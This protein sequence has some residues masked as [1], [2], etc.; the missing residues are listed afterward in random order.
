M[1]R[2]TINAMCA[3]F[4]GATDTDPWGDG[5]DAWKIGGKMFA[6]MGASD[7]GVSVKTDRIETAAMLIDAGIGRRARYFHRSWI[8]LPFDCA[9]D[10]L[11]QRLAV[12]YR[13]VRS[14]LPARVRAELP[15]EEDPALLR[16]R[17][18]AAKT[19]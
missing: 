11:W 10:Q 8:N 1:G 14:A 18:Q 4:P 2:A 7:E 9:E 16:S 13:I 19:T 5:H 6:C 17:Y 12:S 15:P 3:V